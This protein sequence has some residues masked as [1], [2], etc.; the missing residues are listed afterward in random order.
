MKLQAYIVKLSN[1][2]EV[3]IDP[4]EVQK[5]L[6]GVSRGSMVKVRQGLINPSFIVAVV[7]DKKRIGDFLQETK[8]SDPETQAKR[9]A[10]LHALGDIFDG[11]L[12]AG[13]GQDR[14]QIGT[15]R[16]LIPKM[17]TPPEP[18]SGHYT[19]QN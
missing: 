1:N 13:M 18:Y 17:T 3:P 10:G 14:A 19:G 15:G 4:D 8:Y 9:R 5:L 16:D 7:P 12:P 2:A 6:A 11:V